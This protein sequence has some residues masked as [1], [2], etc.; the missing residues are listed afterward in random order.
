M[1]ALQALA[2]LGQRP[3]ID[4]LGIVLATQDDR[5]G[6]YEAA[7][8]IHVAVRIVPRDP[9]AEPERV[10][11]AEGI[12][13]DGLELQAGQPGIPG[14]HFRIEQAF[15]RGEQRA[16]AVHVDTTTL[17]HDLRIDQRQREVFR[18]PIGDLVVVLPVLVLRPGIEMKARD[19]QS[20]F[21]AHKD[22]AEVTR[23]TAVRGETKKVDA[24]EIDPRLLEDA[25]RLR[26]LDPR[27]DENADHFARRQLA[28][29]FAVHPGDRRK[30]PRPIGD[31]VRPADPGRRMRLP[32]GR[33][34][35]AISQ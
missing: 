13:K 21:S 2:V 27:V 33:H 5:A 35:S 22:R 10:R 34:A 24:S 8:V 25:A 23:P 18:R 31:V 7:H 26:L 9:L 19:G 4:V 17:E 3:V 16:A 32:F 14:L 15:F 20:F 30:F 12:A 28:D 6:L 29:D 11:D 1:H